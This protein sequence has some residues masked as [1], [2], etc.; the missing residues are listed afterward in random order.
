M[1]VDSEVLDSLP[2]R[3]FI[4]QEEEEGED[5]ESEREGHDKNTQKGARE[6]RAETNEWH[7]LCAA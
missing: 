2:H 5:N 6:G 4:R 1:I 7:I 3:V